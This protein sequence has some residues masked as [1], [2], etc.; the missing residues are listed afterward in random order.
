MPRKYHSAS[1]IRLGMRC[2]RAWAYRYIDE[3]VEPEVPWDSP[4][5]TSRQRSLGLGKAVHALLESHYRPEE[6]DWS[7]LPGQIA[8]SGM[9]YLPKRVDWLHPELPIGDVPIEGERVPTALEIHGVL[10]GGFVDLQSSNLDSSVALYDYKTS[11]SI[12]KYMPAATTLAGDIQANIYAIDY[13]RRFD[14]ASV[15]CR[16]VYMETKKSRRAAPVDFVVGVECAYHNLEAPA[17]LAKHL[18]TLTSSADAPCNP[19][20]CADYGGCEYYR[21]PCDV[22]RSLGARIQAHERSTRSM[23][24]PAHV[25]EQQARVR[26][27]QVDLSPEEADTTEAPATTP[28]PKRDRKRKP[29]KKAETAQT[30]LVDLAQQIAEKEAILLATSEEIAELKNALRAALEV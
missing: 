23:A 4:N 29:P 26:A 7:D 13:A 12:A 5:A 2:H 18:D 6:V 25:K 20:A 1:S 28:P 11:A 24:I 16:W 19:A 3:L 17:A 14:V 15:P 9:S 10:W 30:S 21:N 8:A 22:R 27:Q